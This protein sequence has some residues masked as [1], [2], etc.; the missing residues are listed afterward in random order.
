MYQGIGKQSENSQNN[1]VQFSQLLLGNVSRNI[2]GRKKTCKDIDIKMIIV[3][4][5]EENKLTG[6]Y[7]LRY[8]CHK[9][10][11]FKM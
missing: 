11:K 2:E 9:R 7:V 8:F 5:K 10:I 6:K 4:R 3:V 1:Q